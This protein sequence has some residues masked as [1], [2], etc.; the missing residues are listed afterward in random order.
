MMDYEQLKGRPVPP[1]G[2]RLRVHRN[3]NRRSD[4]WYSVSLPHGTVLG[5][6]TEVTLAD[7]T[8]K[9]SPTA[10]A[11]IAGGQARSVHAWAVGT[12]T[13][14]PTGLPHR[15]VIYRPHQSPDFR[16]LDTDETFTGAELVVF[17]RKG[18]FAR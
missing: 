10:Q 16:Y 7:V 14:T 11:L 8:V 17:T 18:V 3:L 12:L 2:T 6:S 5:Y 15:Q 13:Y 1:M 4:V 9:T